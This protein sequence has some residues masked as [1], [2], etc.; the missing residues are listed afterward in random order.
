VCQPPDVASL[1]RFLVH[2]RDLWV[3]VEMWKEAVDVD[4]PDSQNPS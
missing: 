2:E 1:V 3:G 4:A